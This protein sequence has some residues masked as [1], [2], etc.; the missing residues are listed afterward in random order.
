[1]IDGDRP[2]QGEPEA[3]IREFGRAA[4]RLVTALAVAAGSTEATA[5]ACVFEL[6][7]AFGQLTSALAVLPEV[8][9]RADAGSRVETQLK[10]R[11]AEAAAAAAGLA[12]LRA[13]LDAMGAAER[14]VRAIEAEQV[15]LAARLAEL[16]QAS[17]RAGQLSAMRQRIADLE[18]AVRPDAASDGLADRLTGALA[19]LQELAD[20][21]RSALGPQLAEAVAKAQA[22][23]EDLE[24]TKARKLELDADFSRLAAEADEVSNAIQRELPGLAEWRQADTAIAD[25]LAAAGMPDSGTTLDRLRAVLAEQT[26]RMQAVEGA[27]GPLH[28]A[29]I[30]A[31]AAALEPRNL[32]APTA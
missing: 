9:S 5:L 14:D 31:R 20:E 25:A 27:L 13:N 15:V 17:A 18:S 1:M 10:Q 29:Y 22:A 8:I 32:S 7:E 3:A 26:E 11:H 30:H 23:G 4:G 12:E 24:R 16:E 19:R 21:E 6:H 28:T 2:V